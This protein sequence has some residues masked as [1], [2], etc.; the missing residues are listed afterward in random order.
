MIAIDFRLFSLSRTMEELEEEILVLD[1]EL[2]AAE[3]HLH[4]LNAR[5]ELLAKKMAKK[6][7]GGTN[8]GEK[9]GEKGGK[10]GKAAKKTAESTRE[11][12]SGRK[13]SFVLEDEVDSALHYLRLGLGGA[14]KAVSASNIV[15][16]LLGVWHTPQP[17][18]N[19]R[20]VSRY[21]KNSGAIKIKKRNRN[22]NAPPSSSQMRAYS[23]SARAQ[24]WQ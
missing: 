18:L 5:R 20:S 16:Y 9:N 17:G 2:K 6:S 4:A 23:A 12:A 10:G 3:A 15:A 22:P 8:L 13:E 7:P 19:E 24:G 21:L 14:R 11:P 1:L